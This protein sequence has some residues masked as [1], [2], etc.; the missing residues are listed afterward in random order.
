MSHFVISCTLC[1]QTSFA[2]WNLHI[3]SDLALQLLFF[4]HYN[5]EPYLVMRARNHN[6]TEGTYDF[7][8]FLQKVLPQERTV[9]L[10]TKPKQPDLHCP[11]DQVAGRPPTRSYPPLSSLICEIG[12]LS[13]SQRLEWNNQCENT[14]SL[15][16]S[17][18]MYLHTE[19]MHYLSMLHRYHMMKNFLVSID[20]RVLFVD[21]P[22]LFL[23]T[24]YYLIKY[25]MM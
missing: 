1:A 9:M 11:W 17:Y 12:W 5:V 22:L 15:Q 10:L 2:S 25:M 3:V 7:P 6:G 16:S 23:T 14:F 4:W 19:F 18:L 24:F 8:C 13:L 20:I 21:H